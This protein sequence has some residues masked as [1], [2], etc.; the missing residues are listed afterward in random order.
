MKH[1][2]RDVTACCI[3]MRINFWDSTRRF[4]LV[5]T[6][7][8]QIIIRPSKLHKQGYF[9]SLNVF[10]IAC[11]RRRDLFFVAYELAKHSKKI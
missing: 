10:E 1:V 2:G 8:V 11:L 6:D 7:R 4:C 3:F 9:R 5:T